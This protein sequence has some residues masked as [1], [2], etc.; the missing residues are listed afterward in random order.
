[1]GV[2]RDISFRPAE[3]AETSSK[4]WVFLKDTHLKARRGRG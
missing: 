4:E 3:E 2:S 1:M